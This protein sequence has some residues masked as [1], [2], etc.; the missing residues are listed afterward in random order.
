MFPLIETAIAFAAAMLAASLFVSAIVQGIQNIGQYRSEIVER[1]L[2]SVIHGFRSFYND[3]DVL[4]ADGVHEAVPKLGPE[5]LK[6]LRALVLATEH[7]FVADV[8][9]DPALHARLDGASYGGDPAALARTVEYIDAA[10]LVTIAR[11]QGESAWLLREAPS[12]AAAVSSPMLE[13][14]TDSSPAPM[15]A[16]DDSRR[17][18]P[19]EWFFATTRPKTPAEM[20]Q[21]KPYATVARF[22]EYVER[23]FPT[24][25]ATASETFKK[26][27]RRLTLVVSCTVV[28]LFNLDGFQLASRLYG[29]SGARDDFSER[30]PDL[31]SQAAR[32][33]VIAADV[34]LSPVSE[35]SKLDLGNETS[36]L[37]SAL[38]DPNLGLGWQN[39]AIVNQWCA[40]SSKCPSTLPALSVGQIGKATLWWMFGLI[41]SCA[42]LSMGAPF[43]YNVLSGLLNL[44]SSVQTRKQ[45]PADA[46]SGA[47]GSS[48]PDGGTAG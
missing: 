7:E 22:A 42:L 4:T 37:L 30:T 12:D 14:G 29:D 23:W 35:D 11:N 15:A 2:K 36:M 38:D 39:S 34:E 47:K 20:A 43:W 19:P 48:L 6:Q 8:L 45:Q 28:V 32:L 31:R 26:R 5:Q 16:P 9:A 24:F 27:M 3:L 18:L 10:D 13:S 17:V 46:G 44:K 25:E 21:L 33:G 41:F 1:M 40:Y